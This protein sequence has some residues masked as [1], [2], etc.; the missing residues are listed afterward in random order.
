MHHSSPPPSPIACS[1][2]AQRLAS[3]R[4]EWEQLCRD[5]MTGLLRTARGVELRFGPGLVPAA[6]LRRLVAL[7]MDCCSFASWTVQERDN[8]LV[9]TVSGPP[10]AVPALHALFSAYQ[11]RKPEAPPLSPAR[12]A[13]SCPA[14]LTH[15]AEV[16][17]EPATET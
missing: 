9:L 16:P 5:F 1:L 11:D 15:R 17:D 2:D 14:G 12:R 4:G 7:E 8:K 3:R 10:D 6:E 13:D